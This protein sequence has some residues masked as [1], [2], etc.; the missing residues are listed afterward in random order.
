MKGT[1]KIT[2]QNIGSLAI[3]AAVHIGIPLLLHIFCPSMPLTD[4]LAELMDETGSF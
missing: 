3:L 2:I 4:S 1:T